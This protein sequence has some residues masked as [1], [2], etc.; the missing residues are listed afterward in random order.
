MVAGA[1]V[2]LGILCLWGASHRKPNPSVERIENKG[3]F[4]RHSTK[5]PNS[6]KPYNHLEAIIAIDLASD[7]RMSVNSF[8]QQ[9]K[10]CPQL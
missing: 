10:N 4:I 8:F 7:Y 9:G 2:L 3:V 5:V 1:L 6:V